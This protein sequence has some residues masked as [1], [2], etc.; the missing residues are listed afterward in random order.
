M[1][2]PL[3]L[4][5]SLVAAFL[6]VPAAAQITAATPP[7]FET[8][9]VGRLEIGDFGTISNSTFG[10]RVYA[11]L[12]GGN[13]TDPSGKLVA[14]LLPGSADTGIIASS[15][16]FY[17]QAILNLRWEAD[18]KLAYLRAEGVGKL[19]ASDM[20]YVHLET[21][22]ETYSVLNDRFLLANLT[23]PAGDSNH[24]IVTIFGAL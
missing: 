17:P 21:D 9:L 10:T 24:A 13:I 23:F 2:T 7:Q 4:L 12:S 16:A 15:G 8:L 11:P 22:S 20:T 14:T 1:R 5:S 6:A 18:Q 19:F 3:A